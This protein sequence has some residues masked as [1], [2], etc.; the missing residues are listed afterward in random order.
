MRRDTLTGPARAAALEKARA[1]MSGNL[2]RVCGGVD[3]F[4]VEGPG[5]W[6]LPGEWRTAHL[7]GQ[8]ARF[9]E[10]A[11]AAG[12]AGVKAQA[13]RTDAERTDSPPVVRL[14]PGGD[15]TQEWRG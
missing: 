15:F 12:R 13:E 9:C 3:G 8:A 6:T 1:G 10:A 2:Y 14:G 7:A 4:R 11:H 5:T